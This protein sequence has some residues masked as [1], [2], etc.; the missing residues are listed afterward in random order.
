MKKE[1]D[2]AAVVIKVKDWRRLR[3]RVAALEELQS[4]EGA[5]NQKAYDAARV[6]D[7]WRRLSA[8]EARVPGAKARKVA[9]LAAAS[10]FG[11]CW[12]TAIEEARL[13]AAAK[14]EDKEDEIEYFPQ[15]A[16]TAVF[17]KQSFERRFL[18]L[19]DQVKCATENL[20]SDFLCL[21]NRTE[22]AFEEAKAKARL[23]WNSL[24]KQRLDQTG[25]VKAA[26]TE[27]LERR[28]LAPDAAVVLEQRLIALEDRIQ[29]M[30]ERRR[31]DN[32]REDAIL[33]RLDVLEYPQRERDARRAEHEAKQ[34]EE[35]AIKRQGKSGTRG[36]SPAEKRERAIRLYGIPG[37][38]HGVYSSAQPVIEKTFVKGWKPGV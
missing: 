31:N 27:V 7:F 9:Q 30:R 15:F 22:A 4:G 8:L 28:L 21:R 18:A 3:D 33:Q 2:D 5:E 11:S 36:L 12:Y 29:R 24:R 32:A 13:A 34:R 37:D 35:S 19:E 20:T 6:T 14:E 10:V 38:F 25:G 16:E 26:A 1:Y 17:A 23:D